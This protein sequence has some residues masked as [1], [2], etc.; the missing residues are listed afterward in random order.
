MTENSRLVMSQGPQPGQTF[1]I[2]KDLVTIGR[3]PGNDITINDPQASRQHA[4]ITR[5]GNLVVIE[6]LGSTNGTFVNGMRLTDPH[7]LAN[8]DVVGLGD[9]V[10]LTYYGAGAD[11]GIAAGVAETE[12]LVGQPTPPPPSYTPP[13]PPPAQGTP[14]PRP[15]YGTPPPPPAYGTPPPPPPAYGAPPPPPAYGVPGEE[16]GSRAGLWIG[17]GCLALFVVTGIGLGLFLWFAPESFWQALIDMGI[18]VPSMP[19]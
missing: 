11:E 13:P 10:R 17:C 8:G 7:T 1:I 3:D 18:P 2:D 4:R 19:F 6:D 14:P 16:E 15:A 9:S 5:Q 12:T